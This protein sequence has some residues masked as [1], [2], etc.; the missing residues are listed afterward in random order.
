MSGAGSD[1]V[2][3]AQTAWGDDIPDWV[4]AL[5]QECAASS[6]N[7]VAKEMDRSATVISN[8]L[9]N[10]YL[11]SM[12]AVEDIFRGVFE[13][14]VIDCPAMG[15]LPTNECRSWRRKSGTLTNRNPRAVMM[16]R[17]CMHCPVNAEPNK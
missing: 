9:R 3:V 6:Q 13:A 16:H 5:A 2:T 4:L 15:Y 8:V 7:K 1:P 11:G 14:K 17:A 10:K 12:E